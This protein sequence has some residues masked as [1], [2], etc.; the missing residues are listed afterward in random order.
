M[1]KDSS[2]IVA[3]AYQRISYLFGKE[4]DNLTYEEKGEVAAFIL[5]FSVDRPSLENEL[6]QPLTELAKEIDQLI[7]ET[8]S[9]IVYTTNL[10]ISRLPNYKAYTII[11]SYSEFAATLLRLR[12]IYFD[13][14]KNTI[15]NVIYARL[16]MRSMAGDERVLNKYIQFYPAMIT[17][18]ELAEYK[19]IQAKDNSKHVW[20]FLKDKGDD[21]RA[22]QARANGFVI[23][24]DTNARILSGANNEDLRPDIA[25]G[26]LLYNQGFN[27][28][29]LEDPEDMEAMSTQLDILIFNRIRLVHEFNATIE[30]IDR[31]KI[32]NID[33]LDLLKINIPDDTL[34]MYH[35]ARKDLVQ[36][37]KDTD[38]EVDKK[39]SILDT[40]FKDL[41]IEDLNYSNEQIALATIEI[42]KQALTERELNKVDKNKA[43]TLID[44]L[45]AYN[46][47]DKARAIYRGDIL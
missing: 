39:I 8:K 16:Y 33:Y 46:L 6:I 41:S 28:T 32:F 27:F 4:L 38:I 20:Q 22:R 45:S 35:E 43:K 19:K 26:S 42:T 47:S 37:I 9:E 34:D 15:S 5:F 44:R 17:E 3:A 18:A 1:E 13:A 14:W 12:N 30:A 2:S 36:A 10:T 25:D 29:E 7:H 40:V 24:N 31:A 21:I 23:L 11:E